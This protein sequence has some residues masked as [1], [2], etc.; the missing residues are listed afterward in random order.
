M[1]QADIS[2]TTP[3]HGLPKFHCVNETILKSGRSSSVPL[4]E[5][6]MKKESLHVKFASFTAQFFA[7]TL[8]LVLSSTVSLGDGPAL[9]HKAQQVPPIQLG[10][11]G[12][13]IDLEVPCY[14]GTLGSLLK[15]QDGNL[16]I[17]SNTHVLAGVNEGTI[18]ALVP[19]GD[20]IQHAG[21]L[22][23][24]FFPEVCNNLG[25]L[26]VDIVAN[27]WD[28]VPLID[29]ELSEDGIVDAAI[30][31]VRTDCE[32]E[33]G[34]MVSCVNTI[35]RILDI[36]PINPNVVVNPTVGMPVKKS[37]RTTGFTRG[38]IFDTDAAILVN[39]G[40]FSSLYEHQ[41]AIVGTEPVDSFSDNGDSGSL[42]VLDEP[43]YAKSRPVGL[44]FAGK[45]KDF[46][47]GGF[48]DLTIAH[49]IQDVLDA[50][51]DGD[52]ES[53]D[54][55]DLTFVGDPPPDS[56]SDSQGRSDPRMEEAVKVHK[57]YSKSL[58]SLP[59]VVGHGVG[60]SNGVTGDAVI[61]VYLK[62][63]TPEALRALPTSLEGV[64]VKAIMTGKFVAY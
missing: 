3:L 7:C 42:I 53:G 59:E 17:L 45:G 13:N 28:Y 23:S 47:D 38:E 25:G 61:H 16:Y 62:K 54:E 27:L 1:G 29:V 22:D 46:M 11:T 21:A 63:R 24:G 2:L 37:G 19:P 40:P 44:L 55:Y 48:A 52:A 20:E 41:L 30:A 57:K 5:N 35:G 60:R 43:Y 64:A 33:H 51:A 26:G 15:D 39:Y 8:L 9:E 4:R 49:P 10:A 56:P 34:H 50:F 12:S 6:I 36:G 32:D 14:V 58:L 31:R 18:G